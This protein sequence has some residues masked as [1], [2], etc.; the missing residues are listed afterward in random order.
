[1]MEGAGTRVSGRRPG[2]DPQ[3]HDR[4]RLRSEAAVSWFRLEL[5][6]KVLH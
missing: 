3:H 4:Q 5:V 1:M 6:P 2:V